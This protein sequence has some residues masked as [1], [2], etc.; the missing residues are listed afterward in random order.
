M[1]LVNGKV[2]IVHI[3]FRARS[4]C[5]KYMIRQECFFFWLKGILPLEDDSHVHIKMRTHSNEYFSLVLFQ[6]WFFI[7]FEEKGGANHLLLLLLLFSFF[8]FE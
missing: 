1:T 4:S 7:F 3:E 2:K 6:H 5:I 8:F